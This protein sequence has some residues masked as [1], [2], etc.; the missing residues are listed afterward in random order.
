MAGYTSSYCRAMASI[1]HSHVI[2]SGRQQRTFETTWAPDRGVADVQVGPR[3]R[4][5]CTL[6]LPGGENQSGC[7]PLKKANF[8]AQCDRIG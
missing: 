3:F 5:R 7:Q 2:F 4:G 6:Q 8:G 1:D